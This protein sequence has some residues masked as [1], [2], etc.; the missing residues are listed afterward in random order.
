MRKPQQLFWTLA[1]LVGG[2]HA[3]ESLVTSAPCNNDTG[4]C[5][6]STTSGDLNDQDGMNYHSYKQQQQHQPQGQAAHDAYQSFQQ[7][8]KLGTGSYSYQYHSDTMYQTHSFQTPS[9][10][11][12]QSNQQYDPRQYKTHQHYEQRAPQEA[13]ST[14]Y[15]AETNVDNPRQT[16]ASTTAVANAVCEDKNDSCPQWADSGACKDNPEYMRVNCRKSCMICTPASRL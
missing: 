13:S 5:E 16:V 11:E 12:A 4:T 6:A 10:Q 14:P 1:L 7:Q 9:R 15:P 3:L 2:V 8:M